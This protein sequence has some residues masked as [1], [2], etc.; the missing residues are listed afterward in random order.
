MQ[1]FA[2]ELIR[3]NTIDFGNSQHTLVFTRNVKALSHIGILPELLR[4]HA[5]LRDGIRR[6]D[7]PEQPALCIGPR[8]DELYRVQR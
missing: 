1:I 8:P 5:H 6:V 7:G 3:E 4:R 2:D